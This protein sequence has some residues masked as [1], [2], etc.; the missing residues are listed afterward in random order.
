MEGYILL[1]EQHWVTLWKRNPLRAH[2][3][4]GCLRVDGMRSDSPVCYGSAVRQY[5]VL[6][7]LSDARVFEHMLDDYVKSARTPTPPPALLSSDDDEDVL[8]EG[9]CGVCGYSKGGE[10]ESACP[11]Y[12]KKQ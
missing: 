8:H 12:Q 3:L 1:L 4:L 5:M 11:H 2:A 7:P 9:Q 10:D 6:Y